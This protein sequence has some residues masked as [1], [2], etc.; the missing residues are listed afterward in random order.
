MPDL[1]T[2]TIAY[3]TA[4]TRAKASEVNAKMTHIWACLRSAIYI[5]FTPGYY[6]ERR[7]GNHTVNTAAC[8]MAG[9]Y[10]VQYG[11]T[12]SLATSTARAV[13]FGECEVEDTATLHIGSGAVAKIV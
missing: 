5:P 3:F 9:Y 10:Q 8:F 7:N 13:F 1:M 4:G 11:A 12:F 2:S 6:N